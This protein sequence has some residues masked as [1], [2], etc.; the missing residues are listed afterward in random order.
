MSEEDCA[1]AI[2][3]ERALLKWYE[4]ISALSTNHV[5]A[6]LLARS[7]TLS[8]IDG[9]AAFAGHRILDRR[10]QAAICARSRLLFIHFD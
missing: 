10:I 9:D 8:W 3:F 1:T 7:V 4:P 5:E 2:P 6:G